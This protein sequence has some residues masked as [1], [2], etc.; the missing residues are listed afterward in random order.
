M[1]SAAWASAS[2]TGPISVSSFAGSPTRS[3]AIAPLSMPM[4]RSAMASC[5]QRTRSAEQRW[6]AELKAEASTS[7]TT[8]SGSAEESTIIAFWPPV[9]ATKGMLP[10]RASAPWMW[11]ATSV[12]P[13]NSTALTRWVG[14]ERRANLSSARNELQDVA[15]DA[16]FVQKAHGF[17]GDQRRLL[18]RFGK[19][20]IARRERC[21]DLAGEDR[22]REVPRADADRRAQAARG[23]GSKRAGLSR[24][25]AAEIGGLAHFRNGVGHGSAG[26]AHDQLA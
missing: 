17:G 2:I 19:H 20:G 23:P 12:E 8:C 3:S 4:T 24:V 25:I 10:R 26:L 15:R 13:V 5:R 16:G 1:L 7:P 21:R 11:R 18:G 14:N 22:E 9:S 6:P